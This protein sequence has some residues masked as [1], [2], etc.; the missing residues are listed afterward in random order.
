[1]FFFKFLRSYIQNNY[2]CTYIPV[3]PLPLV[4]DF[5]PKHHHFEPDFVIFYKSKPFI[6]EIDGSSHCDK[7]AYEE[8]RRL[9]PLL[10]NGFTAVHIDSPLD[11]SDENLES[12]AKEEVKKL[13][14]KMEQFVDMWRNT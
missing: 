8:Q 9:E 3:L 7:S 4:V 13:F 6:I 14:L 11:T 10:L 5:L 1:M 12:W 2:T